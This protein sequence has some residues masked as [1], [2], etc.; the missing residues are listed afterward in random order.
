MFFMSLNEVPATS[1]EN[2]TV[3]ETTFNNIPVY[4][5]IPNRKLEALRRGL[6]YIHSGGWGILKAGRCPL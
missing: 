1:D 3:M 5:Y 4:I 2:V 6:F